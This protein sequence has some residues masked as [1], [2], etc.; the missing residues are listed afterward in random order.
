[1]SSA[2]F[3]AGLMDKLD[4]LA[5][6]LDN[7]TTLYHNGYNQ[8]ELRKLFVRSE[9]PEFINQDKV[10]ALAEKIVNISREGLKQRGL[11]EER[12]LSPLYERIE[13]RTNPA[14]SMTARLKNGESLE[15]VVKSF[16]EL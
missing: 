6:I 10:Y 8:S 9:L 4:E 1:M 11:G 16:A 13:T 15:S 7:D 3:H 2:A 14:K 12:F 5:Y